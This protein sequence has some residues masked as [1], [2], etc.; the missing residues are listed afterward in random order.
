MFE[1]IIEQNRV[2]NL[3]AGSILKE[4]VSHAYLFTGR[5]GIGKM[6]MAQEFGKA[7]LCLTAG[8]NRPCGKCISCEKIDHGN[9]PDFL[10]VEPKKGEMTIKIEQI[11]KLIATLPIK[12]YE[13]E[14][15][16]TVI[17]GS[18]RMTIDA[19]NALLKSLEEPEPHNLF[20]L[21]TENPQKIVNTIRSRCQTLQFEPISTRGLTEIIKK[22]MD[23]SDK[24]IKQAIYDAE[25]AP[26]KALE[27]LENEDLE[28][29]KIEVLNDFYAILKGDSFKIFGLSEK[30]GKDK[31]LSMT[32][33]NFLVVWFHGMSLFLE[34]MRHAENPYYDKQQRFAEVLTKERA[35]QVIGLLFELMDTL[36]YNVN[37][38]LQWE[39]ILLQI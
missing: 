39:C 22:H 18:D 35:T 14:K 38:R 10:L 27:F 37:L 32:I 24:E 5:K 6:F 17:N 4:Q 28:K 11:R 1:E 13:S 12:P 34:G 2:K 9:H 7:L 29:L 16:I 26:G 20:I 3:L 15:R 30:L 25:G 33:L 36:Q 23:V 19:Q 8:D 31:V 21:I